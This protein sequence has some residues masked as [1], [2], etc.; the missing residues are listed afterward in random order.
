MS[1]RRVSPPISEEDVAL[2]AGSHDI[3]EEISNSPTTDSSVSSST[4]K[5]T[6][7]F[8]HC[9]CMPESL[10]PFGVARTIGVVFAV[11]CCNDDGGAAAG[12]GAGAAGAAAGL[13]ATCVVGV[14]LLVVTRFTCFCGRAASFGG[15]LEISFSPAGVTTALG[16]GC[17]TSSA[18]LVDLLSDAFDIAAVG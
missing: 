1:G 12:A 3:G 10:L 13:V 18:V 2:V 17:V 5:L 15:C 8:L 4:S 9:V 6:R 14:C 11:S 7:L 16:P